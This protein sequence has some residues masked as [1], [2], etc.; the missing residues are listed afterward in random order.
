M[1]RRSKRLVKD[2]RT[3]E[4]KIEKR[5][6][7]DLNIQEQRAFQDGRKHIAIISA[8]ASTGISLHADR[9]AKNQ[10]RR[11]HIILESKWS[12]DQQMQDFGRTNRTNQVVPP[13]YIL[14]SLDVGGEKRFFATIAPRL[15][16]L[17]ALSRGQRDASGGGELAKYNYE[18][19]FG[20]QAVVSIIGALQRTDRPFPGLEGGGPKALADMGLAVMQPDGRIADVSTPD[21]PQFLNRVLALD[22]DRQ[23]V[24]FDAFVSRMADAIAFAKETGAFDEGVEDVKADAIRLKED[25]KVVRE[26]TGAAGGAK[27]VYYSLEADYRSHPFT[28]ERAAAILAE[29]PSNTLVRNQRS[30]NY[31]VAQLLESAETDRNGKTHQRYRLYNVHG[32]RRNVRAD[33]LDSKFDRA[34]MLDAKEAGEAW[35]R[36]QLSNIGTHYTEPLH[37][38]GGSILPIWDVLS[39]AR[40]EGAKIVRVRTDDGKRI[41][42]VAIPDSAIREVLRGLGV[43]NEN[44]TSASVYDAVANHDET[45][46]L[47]SDLRIRMARVAGEQRIEVAGAKYADYG[48][49]VRL[50]AKREDISY[51][52]RFFIPFSEADALPVLER[53]LKRFPVVGSMT[54]GNIGERGAGTLDFRPLA[55]RDI[56]SGA[57]T[58]PDRP[59]RGS[60]KPSLRRRARATSPTRHSNEWCTG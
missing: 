16:Q 24:V 41:I 50:G 6:G 49:L 43:G 13:E 47:I 3:G 35:W 30:G 45:V 23:N 12:A 46:G 20:W 22:V 25:P 40:T 11:R 17:G 26:N 53:I 4:H 48:E 8:A 42:G 44:V 36:E 7:R 14:L 10:Q 1:T 56:S 28:W 15:E 5:T 58:P 37:V 57:T 55:W 31:F 21:V 39:K 60:A 54:G 38:I 9:R 18:S 32:K 34:T 59:S 52:A 27:T 29:S 2:P 33:E 51:Q 19:E